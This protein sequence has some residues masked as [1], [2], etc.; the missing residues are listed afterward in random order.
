MYPPRQ[1]F[2]HSVPPSKLTKFFSTLCVCRNHTQPTALHQRLLLLQAVSVSPIVTGAQRAHPSLQRA[3]EAVLWPQVCGDWKSYADLGNPQKCQSS[4]SK[5]R[6]SARRLDETALVSEESS[7]GRVGASRKWRN[8][9]S[10]L[11][12]PSASSVSQK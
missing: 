11:L 7:R 1:I 2:H 5:G 9:K 6:L 8:W 4:R 10:K 3:A 12:Q